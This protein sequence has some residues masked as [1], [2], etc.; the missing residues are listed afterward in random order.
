MRCRRLSRAPRRWWLTQSTL[1]R[2]QGEL[3]RKYGFGYR[4][5]TLVEK[6]AARGHKPR[7]ILRIALPRYDSRARRDSLL[8]GNP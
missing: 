3:R 2:L 1:D 7:V 8:T 6:I 4:I 5:V